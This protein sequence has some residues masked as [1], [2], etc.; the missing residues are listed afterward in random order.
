MKKTIAILVTCLLLIGMNHSLQAQDA[1][2]DSDAAELAKQTANPLANMIS[3]PV[4]FNFN[5]GLGEYNRTQTLINLMPVIP[6]PL[7]KKLNVINRIILPVLIQPD[8]AEESGSTFG[9]GD[10]NYSMFFTPQ[11]AGKLIWGIGPAL[12]IPTRTNNLL[13][14][15]EFGIGPSIIAL[16]MP[17]NWAIGLTANNVW[18]YSNSNLSALFSQVF[19][20]YTFPSAFFVQM[21]PTIT[22]NWNAPEGQQ[23]SIPLGANMGKVVMFGKQPVKFIG[24]GSYYVVSPDNGP[25]WQLFFQAV[26][27]FPKKKG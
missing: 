3:L 7:G 18:S 2:A 19:V 11:K 14:S 6:Y 5:F 13:G 23:W 21:M 8:V 26:F 16:T 20:V 27:L 15:P 1:S 10:I 17:G 9:I 12:N 22:A 24:G 25:T 4:Q